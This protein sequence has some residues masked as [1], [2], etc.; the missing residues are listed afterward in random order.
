MKNST[1]SISIFSRIIYF[2]A[3]ITTATS[4]WFHVRVKYLKKKYTV[5]EVNQKHYISECRKIKS[6]YKKLFD[7]QV[8]LAR[9]VWMLTEGKREYRRKLTNLIK[10]RNMEFGIGG[11]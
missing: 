9:K 7:E 11:E 1:I 3:V 4:I 6:G 8:S 5:L 2:V 10:E